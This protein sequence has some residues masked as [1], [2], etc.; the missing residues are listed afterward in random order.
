M[1]SVAHILIGLQHGNCYDCHFL[2][3]FPSVSLKRE[4]KDNQWL[5]VTVKSQ[6]IGGKV[7]VSKDPHPVNAS[8]QEATGRSILSYYNNVVHVQPLL[9][10]S[11]CNK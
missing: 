5:G 11:C 1:L 8:V 9:R 4:N 10:G 3:C 2:L 7:V 6:G